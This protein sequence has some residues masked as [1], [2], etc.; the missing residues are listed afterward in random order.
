MTALASLAGLASEF[1][2]SRWPHEREPIE[3]A[4]LE[5]EKLRADERQ[6]LAIKVRNQVKD[7]LDASRPS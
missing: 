6:D 1:L 4:V 2:A 7:L 5:A 3:A